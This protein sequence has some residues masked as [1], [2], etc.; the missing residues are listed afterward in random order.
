MCA[1]LNVGIASG[2]VDTDLRFQ[3]SIQFLGLENVQVDREAPADNKASESDSHGNLCI[4][5]ISHNSHDGREDRTTT[6]ASYEE[7]GTALSMSPQTTKGQ[8]EDRR[9]DT[10]LE[11]ENQSECG[12]AAVS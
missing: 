1:V 12:N 9:E 4:L 2:W 10:G 5:V 11:E 8:R 6:D 3:V 7:R